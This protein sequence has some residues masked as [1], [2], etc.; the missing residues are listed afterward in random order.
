MKIYL[1]TEDGDT[2]CRRAETMQE[3]LT[4]ALLECLSDL[5]ALESAEA[6]NE[7]EEI[8][9]YHANIL[10]SCTL[11]GPFREFPQVTS[12]SAKTEL[13]ATRYRKLRG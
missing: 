3:A 1:I 11:V 9:Y 6:S 4:Q 5:P 10:E 8:A 7:T 13:A 12:I 2:H